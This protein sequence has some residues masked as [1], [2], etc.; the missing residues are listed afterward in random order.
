MPGPWKVST[1]QM[2]AQKTTVLCY[3]VSYLQLV[4]VILAAGN[5]RAVTCLP[6]NMSNSAK[7]ELQLKEN[8]LKFKKPSY[9]QGEAKGA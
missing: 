8:K 7:T 2:M 3:T 5:N 9:N 4:S 1:N 6:F